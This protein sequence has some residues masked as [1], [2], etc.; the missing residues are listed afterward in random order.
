MG[1]QHATVG[2]DIL[3]PHSFWIHKRAR[4]G[5]VV[6]HYKE[7][8]ADNVWLPPLV[9]NS[10][11]LVTDPEGIEFLNPNCPPVDPMVCTPCEMK[12]VK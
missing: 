11:P 9:R 7:L 3:V 5:C 6:L 1:I 10:S 4:D 8:S 2:E 12:L